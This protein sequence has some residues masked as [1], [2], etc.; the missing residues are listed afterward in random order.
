M[1]HYRFFLG[2]NQGADS[3]NFS[4]ISHALKFNWELYYGLSGLYLW[5]FLV[6]LT[7]SF[8][9]RLILWDWLLTETGAMTLLTLIAAIV[10]E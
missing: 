7:D 10:Y 1:G 6:A 8:Q 2:P 5:V 3:S 4:A 9:P